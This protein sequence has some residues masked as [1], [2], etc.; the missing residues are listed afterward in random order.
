MGTV[1]LHGVWHA[2]GDIL[3][4]INAQQETDWSDVDCF[5]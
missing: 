5:S 4:V 1:Q 2:I 3:Q